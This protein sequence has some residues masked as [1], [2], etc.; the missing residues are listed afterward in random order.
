MDLSSV[1]PI[2]HPSSFFF[3]LSDP[4]RFGVF[5]LVVNT[6]QFFLVEDHFLAALARQIVEARQFDGIDRAGFFAHAAID[7]AKFVDCEGLG[8]FFAVGPRTF[9]AR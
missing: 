2:P 1:I 3:I 4:R 6:Q 8:I 9:G 5:G 7:T